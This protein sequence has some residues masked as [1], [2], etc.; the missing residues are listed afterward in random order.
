MSREKE[1]GE[2]SAAEY[3]NP[4]EAVPPEMPEEQGGPERPAEEVPPVKTPEK[5]GGEDNPENK[6]PETGGEGGLVSI[7][8]HAERLKVS[9]PILAAVMQSEGWATGKAVTEKVFKAAIDAFLNAPM[10]GKPEPLKDGDQNPPKEIN[11]NGAA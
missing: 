1:S 7:E 8:E 5:S 6:P 4:A 10:G 3:E 9:K 2:P 11:S